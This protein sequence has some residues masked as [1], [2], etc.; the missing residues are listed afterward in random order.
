MTDS[1]QKTPEK[2]FDLKEILMAGY[3]HVLDSKLKPDKIYVSPRDYDR[4]LK[5]IEESERAVEEQYAEIHS[6]ANP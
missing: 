4:K 2:E 3:R 6:Q 1:T 5:E